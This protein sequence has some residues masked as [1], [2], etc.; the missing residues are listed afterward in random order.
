M[1][2]VFLIFLICITFNSLGWA[3]DA[4]SSAPSEEDKASFDEAAKKTQEMMKDKEAR[5]KFIKETKGAGQADS[6]AASVAGS[7]ENLDEMYS[8]SADLVSVIGEQAGG[9][10]EKMKELLMK[11]QKDPAGFLKSLPPEQRKKI[12]GLAKKIEQQKTPTKAR[13]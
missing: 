12:S 13:P 2:N 1:K 11:A 3:H 10:P 4:H 7:E 5:K 9:D 6:A 8:I